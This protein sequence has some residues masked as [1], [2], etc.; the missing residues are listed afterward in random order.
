M[1][2]DQ[3]GEKE[4]EESWPGNEHCRE[5]EMGKGSNEDQGGPFVIK[6]IGEGPKGGC[7]DFGGSHTFESCFGA[8]A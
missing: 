5:S 3:L 6:R 4:S 1:H 2:I 8:E 7:F